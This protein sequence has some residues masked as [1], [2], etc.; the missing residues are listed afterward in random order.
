MSQAL[1]TEPGFTFQDAA[2]ATVA[3][4]ESFQLWEISQLLDDAVKA[5]TLARR[6]ADQSIEDLVA[7]DTE[8]AEKW[9]RDQGR[10]HL[11]AARV[12]DKAVVNLLTTFNKKVR[13]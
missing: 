1:I 5:G 12:A 2:N 8:F 11:D 9:C 4:M 7:A 6:D 3:E 10:Q 13:L